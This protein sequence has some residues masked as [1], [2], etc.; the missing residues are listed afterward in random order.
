MTRVRVKPWIGQ[1]RRRS[2]RRRYLTLENLGL[3]RGGW[4]KFW[5]SGAVVRGLPGW[6]FK[7][8][9]TGLGRV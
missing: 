8:F 3:F 6:P 9:G 7:E 5:P 2:S 1:D 4:E